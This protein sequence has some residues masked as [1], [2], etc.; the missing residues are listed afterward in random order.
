M[1]LRDELYA[2]CAPPSEVVEINGI[3]FR[4]VGLGA[5]DQLALLEM[6]EGADATF[7]VLERMIRDGAERAFQDGDPYLRG[8]DIE[9]VGKLSEIAIRL[10]G[11]TAQA[12]NSEAVQSSE[13]S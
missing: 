3:E 6:G 10:M 9:T 8:L 4:M 7:W 2:A 5:E 11:V 1:S 12:K 13:G